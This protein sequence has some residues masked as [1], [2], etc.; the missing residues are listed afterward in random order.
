MSKNMSENSKS[1]SIKE[2]VEL[3]GISKRTLERKIKSGDIN[4][5]SI[6]LE[7][8]AR[9]IELAALIKVFGEP[10][11]SKSDAN[12][13]EAPELPKEQE[14]ETKEGAK[15]APSQE[16][17]ELLKDQLA[18]AEAR[19]KAERERAESLQAELSEARK[20]NDELSNGLILKLHEQTKKPLEIAPP[21]QNRVVNFFARIF[22]RQ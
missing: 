17:I 16:L 15:S 2:A 4:S 13:A 22:N 8:G 20:R 18:K 1:L 5:S 19:E 9:F 14:P 7:N 12:P 10:S 11:R 21:P 6:T 3:F